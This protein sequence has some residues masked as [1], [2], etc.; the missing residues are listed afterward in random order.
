VG[1]RQG[2]N[3]LRTITI[4][5]DL[6]RLVGVR[7]DVGA[8][9][10]QDVALAQADLERIRR[11]ERQLVSA[12]QQIVRGLEALLGRYPSDELQL[13][14]TIAQL[15]GPV[16]EGLPAE[17]LERRP[18]LVAAERRVAAAFYGIQVAKAARLPAVAI[19]AAGGRSTNEIFKLVGVSP[20][21]W[22]V[23]AGFLAPLFSA[24]AL[25]AG[26]DIATAEQ[27]AAVALYGQTVLRAFQEVESVLDDETLLAEQQVFL[28]SALAQDEEAVR[29][30]RIQYDV[31][32]IDLLS[33][34]QLQARQ[35]DTEFD[36]ITLR[37]DRLSNRIALH[38]A[39]GGGF[40]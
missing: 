11:Q 26:V 36:L 25:K 12:Q 5:E 16:P 13:A 14:T 19:T 38:L 24:G 10:R 21:F 18:D 37:N 40:R 34:L 20:N 27:R 1:T 8:A 33:V 9:S 4:Y 31:G 30:G 28:E 32:Q 22:A 29:L 2:E 7:F 3:A 39:L 15:P 23:G 17:L 35:Y 6:V